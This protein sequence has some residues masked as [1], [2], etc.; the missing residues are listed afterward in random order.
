M[1]DPAESC[2]IPAKGY[3]IIDAVS[4]IGTSLAD[5]SCRSTFIIRVF[6][7]FEITYILWL[8]NEFSHI[9]A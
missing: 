8:A 4:F 6:F 3:Y 2:C 9:P 5:P 1:L 7:D